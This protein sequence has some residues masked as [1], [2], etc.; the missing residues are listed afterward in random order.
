[1][2]TPLYID[3]YNLRFNTNIMGLEYNLGNET[4]LPV[5]VPTG[6]IGLANGKILVGNAS[7]LAS[8][9]A[10]SGGGT[11]SNTGVLSL[12][13]T[14][15]T[16]AVLT[17]YVSG[18]GTVAATDTILQAIQKLNG[19]VAAHFSTGSVT[20]TGTITPDARVQS[21]LIV[22]VTG[23][24]TI[25]GPTNGYDGQTLT[26]RIVNDGT[27]SVTLATGSGN[28]GFGATITGYTNSATA[29]VDYVGVIYNLAKTQ[30]DVVSVSQGF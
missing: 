28:F 20:G 30:W 17:G 13:S 15:V 16:A 7:N 21:T 14:S 1:M 5:P 11:L 2:T 10:M 18:A 19:N 9:V 25:D 3:N 23:A 6:D 8:P 22:N 4:W 12:T 26:L 29:V 27:H 24:T